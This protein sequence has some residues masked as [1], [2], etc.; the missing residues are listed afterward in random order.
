MPDKE[1]KTG[2]GKPTT[3]FIDSRLHFRDGKIFIT[4]KEMYHAHVVDFKEIDVT[5]QVAK[6]IAPYIGTNK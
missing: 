4:A 2:T 6:A 5:E 1:N 3:S